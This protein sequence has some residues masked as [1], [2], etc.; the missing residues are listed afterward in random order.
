MTTS[1]EIFF[2]VE[3]PLDPQQGPQ[4]TVEETLI[5][6]G[7]DVDPLEVDY[8]FTA[9]NSM[10]FARP[11]QAAAFLRSRA[12]N[13]C[14]DLGDDEVER[15]IFE[16]RRSLLPSPS[17]ALLT[18]V[19]QGWSPIERRPIGLKYKARKSIKERAK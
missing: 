3:V 9:L 6:D 1:I 7:G 13:N 11:D 19:H 4:G 18:H 16:N 17:T 15:M 5:K 12:P 2:Q 10:G 14:R 8:S